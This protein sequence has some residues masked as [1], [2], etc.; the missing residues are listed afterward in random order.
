MPRGKR[1]FFRKWFDKNFVI[2]KKCVT[3]QNS[4]VAGRRLQNHAELNKARSRHSTRVRLANL[5]GKTGTVVLIPQDCKNS[6]GVQNHLGRPRPSYRNSAW[7]T[8]GPLIL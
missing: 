3:R 6:R 2:S 4:S 5:V 1:M 7:S 8:S